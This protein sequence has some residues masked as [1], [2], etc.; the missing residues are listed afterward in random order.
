MEENK[1][2]CSFLPKSFTTVTKLSKIVALIMFVSLPFAGFY[3]GMNYQRMLTSSFT[4]TTNSNHENR[5][6]IEEATKLVTAKK[7][8]KEWLLLFTGPGKTNPMTDGR[9]VIAFDRSEGNIYFIHVFE[10]LPDHT[11]T[12]GWYKVNSLTKE[13]TKATSGN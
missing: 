7:E 4:P 5:L 10:D 6:T 12:L 13:V 3:L 2:C 11:A 8:V 9:A 1:S